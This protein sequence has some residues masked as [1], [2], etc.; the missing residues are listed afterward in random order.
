MTQRITQPVSCVSSILQT[1]CQIDQAHPGAAAGKTP[2]ALPVHPLAG[3]GHDILLA[4]QI[5]QIEA[6][7]HTDS[8]FSTK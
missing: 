5:E 8:T 7:F 3:S 4:G 6:V 2:R 1:L